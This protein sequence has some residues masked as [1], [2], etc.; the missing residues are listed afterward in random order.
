MDD[1]RPVAF[2]LFTNATSVFYISYV[3]ASEYLARQKPTTW[4]ATDD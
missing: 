2:F 4:R 3:H 1:A